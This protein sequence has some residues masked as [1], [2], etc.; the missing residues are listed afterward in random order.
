MHTRYRTHR[1]ILARQLKDG[2][3]VWDA[4]IY[5]ANTRRKV[6]GFRTQLEA[7]AEW[8]RLQAA[9]NPDQLSFLTVPSDGDR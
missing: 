6:C 7:I 9:Q 4:V 5:R 2:S 8:Q 1:G 3:T